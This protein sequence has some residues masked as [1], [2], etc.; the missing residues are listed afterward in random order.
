MVC[1]ERKSK[2]RVAWFTIVT[3]KIP[4]VVPVNEKLGFLQPSDQP[5]N[6]QCGDARWILNE[7]KIGFRCFEEKEI[8]E[9][10]NLART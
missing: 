9:L 1:S 3:R 2:N 10:E 8:E 7:V 5:D 6:K 4:K